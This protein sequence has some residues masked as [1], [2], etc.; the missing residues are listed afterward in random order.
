[1]VPKVFLVNQADNVVTAL[2][3]IPPGNVAVIGAVQNMSLVVT[4]AIQDGHKIARADIRQG[5]SIRKYNSCIGKATCG[6]KAGEWV[7]IHN[8]SSVADETRQHVD[9]VTGAVVDT[10][11]E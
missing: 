4:E 8:I 9:A 11:Y 5:E 6:I 2:Q 3:P 10:R 1:M 7:H